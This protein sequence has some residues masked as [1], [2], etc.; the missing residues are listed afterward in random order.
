MS[1]VDVHISARLDGTVCAQGGAARTKCAKV[2]VLRRAGL[3]IP[4]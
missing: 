4:C 1:N 3:T 2:P